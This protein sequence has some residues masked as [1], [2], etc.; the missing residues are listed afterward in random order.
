MTFWILYI[1][2]IN[3]V[4]LLLATA[5]AKDIKVGVISDVHMKHDYSP[6][7]SKGGCAPDKDPKD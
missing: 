6:Y 5:I 3:K 4:F 1:K 2:M 7:S